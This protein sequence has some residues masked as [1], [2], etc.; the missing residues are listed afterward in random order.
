LTDS[1]DQE[2]D[3]QEEGW[4]PD[5]CPRLGRMHVVMAG[6]V[7]ALGMKAIGGSERRLS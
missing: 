7:G 5:D 6:H 3:K 2:P 4:A 1:P